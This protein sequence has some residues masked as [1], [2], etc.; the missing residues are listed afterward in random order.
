MGNIYSGLFIVSKTK[1]NTPFYPNILP[2]AVSSQAQLFIVCLIFFVS[3]RPHLDIC[4]APSKST[5]EG[6]HTVSTYLKVTY[7]GVPTVAQGVRGGCSG[8]GL[9][10]ILT[11]PIKGS[12]VAIVCRSQL[13]LRLDLW[14]R[15]LPSA[16]CTA[17]KTKQNKSYTS[18]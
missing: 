1:L 14:P 5:N 7:Q 9:I 17:M 2:L 12:S 3:T 15:E 4:G 8:V 6:L 10:P 18:N 13:C 11:Q 16:M